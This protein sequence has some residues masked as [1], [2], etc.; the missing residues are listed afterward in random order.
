MTKKKK[1]IRELDPFLEREREQYEHPL[2]SREYILQILAEKGVPL[3]QDDL[4]ALLQ[5]E[6]DEEELF[7]RRLRAME[8]D[9]QTM[10]NRKRAICVMDKLDLIKGKVQGHPDGF[11]FLI[12]E[13]GSADLV[14]SAKEMHNALHGDTVMA[15]VAGEDRRGRREAKIVEVL[16]HANVHVVGRLYE[17]HGIQFVVAENRRISQDILVAAGSAGGAQAGQVVMLEILQQPS[18]H[19]QPIGRIVEVLGN[20]ADP[21][22]EIE[23]ALR[24]HNLPNEFPHDAK[25]QAERFAPVVQP[26]DYAGRESVKHLP[27]VTIDGETA[28]DFDDAVYCEPSGSGFRL[29]VAIADVSSYVQAGDALDTEAINRGNSVYFPRRVIPMLPEELSNGL[30][31][32][33]P[34][35]DR[36]CMVCDMYVSA[37]GEIGEYRFYPSVMFS[38]ARLTYTQVADMLADPKGDDAQKYAEVL[39]HINNLYKLF[40]TLLQA[41]AK[42]GAIDFETVETQMIF[43]DQGKIEKIVPVI[44]NDAHKLIEECMLAANV[45]AA[46][47][48]NEHKHPVL[49]RVHEGPTPEK[50]ETVREFFKEFGLELGGG[51]DPQAGDYSALLKQIKGRPD[52][53]LLQTVMLRSLRQAVYAPDN[54]GHFGLGYEAYAH[55]TSPI[56]RYPDLLVHRAIKAVL[57]QKQYKPKLKWAE[58]GVHCSMTERRADDATRDVEAWLKCF[59]MRDHLGSVFDGTISSVTGFGLFVS[60]DDLYVEGLVHVSEL[61]ADYYHFDA[62]KHQMSGERTGKRYRLGDRVKVKV[63]RVDMESTKIDFVL[64]GETQ[65][66]AKNESGVDVGAWGGAKKK[67][68]KAAPSEKHAKPAGKSGKGAKRHG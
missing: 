19:A 62:T 8:R 54:H 34:N 42:R 41:R 17:E 45:C 28:R 24:K 58:L 25:H 51:D 23:I 7:I 38:H 33:N 22:M 49:Y 10:R 63:V 68:V 39:P 21:G 3:E 11:G 65:S 64:E 36:L 32:L 57:Q 37:E 5:I 13:D 20:Y 48:L 16:E 60:L 2:P 40:Q 12:P 30:C 15:R 27:L 6:H 59:Y 55:F 35:V 1:N 67:P 50:L 14:L 53:G 66:T 26:A 18:K 9:G 4:I 44:R 46:A 52:A 43:N 31:S 29:V 56:R 47:F 61:G